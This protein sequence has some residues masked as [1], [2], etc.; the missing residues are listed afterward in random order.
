MYLPE[1]IIPDL[2]VNAKEFRCN[3]DDIADAIGLVVAAKLK[4]QGMCET[5]PEQPQ[6]DANGLY[7]RLTVP[8]KIITSS[9]G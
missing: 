3:A 2:Y 4:T 8:K 9:I 6:M 1:I 7:M 5:I